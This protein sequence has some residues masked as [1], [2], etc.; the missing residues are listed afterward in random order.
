MAMLIYPNFHYSD[1]CYNEVEVYVKNLMLRGQLL[2]IND[3][4]S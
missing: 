3:V 2:E 1:M 4:I